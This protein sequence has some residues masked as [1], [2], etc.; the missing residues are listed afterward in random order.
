MSEWA[1]LSLSG[2]WLK[3]ETARF[4]YVQCS[5]T[6][7][8]LCLH[9]IATKWL[10]CK[11]AILIQNIIY[12]LEVFWFLAFWCPAK[13]SQFLLTL[14]ESQGNSVFLWWS[15]VPF[16]GNILPKIQKVKIQA[17]QVFVASPFYKLYLQFCPYSLLLLFFLF[18]CIRGLQ[19]N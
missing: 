6:I 14:S 9:Y 13:C 16:K 1:F 5:A 2:P 17:I 18:F 10:R 8:L 7:L 12:P 3:Q 19:T 15:L 4:V 11:K